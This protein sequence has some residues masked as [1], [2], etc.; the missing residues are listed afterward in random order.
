[1]GR[2][3]LQMEEKFRA[4][5]LLDRCSKRCEGLNEGNL[6]VE[7][8]CSITVIWDGTKRKV[9]LWRTKE[10]FSKNR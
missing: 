4:L 10:H 8:V 2:K 9:W 6:S 5:T 3:K 7:E 1:M